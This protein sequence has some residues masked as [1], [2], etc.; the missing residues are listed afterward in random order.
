MANKKRN[1]SPS[2]SSL[3]DTA[4]KAGR[5][6]KQAAIRTVKSL[7]ALIKPGRR[8]IPS[9]SECESLSLYIYRLTFL[10]SIIA[11]A[12]PDGA[13]G[14]QT[15]TRASSIVDMDIDDHP[16]PRASSEMDI[17]PLIEISD[18]DEDSKEAKII[19]EMENKISTQFRY[20]L[21][22]KLTYLLS[23]EIIQKKTWRSVVY[24]F[25]K[26]RPKVVR[27][28]NKKGVRTTYLEFCCVKC[29][30]TYLRGTG[31]DSGSTG[32]MRDHIPVCWG[33]DVWNEAKNLDLDP[34]KDVVKKFKTLKNVKLTE[35]F[36][37]VPGSKE[38][39]SLAPP[40][41]EE[42]RYGHVRLLSF[43]HC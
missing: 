10:P 38:T 40:S 29:S 25:Y 5:K 28:N 37:R 34:A 11:D 19:K 4:I 32:V 3:S 20:S 36:S 33:E 18:D 30:K 22:Q 13:S 31:S 17:N 8:H 15:S 41:R 39:Y 42:I 12:E 43:I 1:R 21:I 26:E 14:V 6:A 2:V 24:A 9:D 27:K 16:S 7:T 35:M 23:A